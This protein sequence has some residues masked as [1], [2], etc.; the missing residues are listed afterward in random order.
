MPS[1]SWKGRPARR[2]SGRGRRGAEIDLGPAFH[3]L[4]ESLP[5][6]GVVL[7]FSDCPTDPESLALGLRHLKYGGHD[8]GLF[9]IVDPAEEA[10]PFD[11][12]LLLEGLEGEGEQR[13]DARW[14]GDAYRAE[15]REFR[16]RLRRPAG[17]IASTTDSPGRTFRRSMCCDRFSDGSDATCCRLRR[18]RLVTPPQE[19]T[20]RRG[21]QNGP[22]PR[23]AG[24]RSRSGR[25]RPTGAPVTIP[26]RES[27]GSSR[28]WPSS[29]RIRVA[30]RRTGESP[31]PVT[32]K[33]S[34][35]CEGSRQVTGRPVTP[36][37]RPLA[38]CRF[39]M[40]SCRPVE[41]HGGLP[42]LQ[43][44]AG[45]GNRVRGSG[46]ELGGTEEEAVACHEEPAPPAIAVP[47]P[48]VVLP[49]EDDRHD[50]GVL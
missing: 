5:Q 6:R 24:T 15:F 4:A 9:H 21:S 22:F 33:A 28:Q 18:R 39:R 17:T 12:P 7:V 29:T 48:A 25:P 46:L 13:V 36:S 8:V 1:S 38:E 35:G 19:E 49:G 30:A 42:G 23:S 34:S 37:T 26:G 40:G 45:S 11:D 2:H 47:E 41:R 50:V 20:R 16:I 14:L 32:M 44:T 10:F 3:A 43:A 31:L 27:S